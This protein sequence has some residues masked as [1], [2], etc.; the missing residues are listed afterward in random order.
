MSDYCD[1]LD[2]CEYVPCIV[3]HREPDKQILMMSN[4]DF[5]QLQKTTRDM[6]IF[7]AFSSLILK[8]RKMRKCLNF[9]GKNRDFLVEALAIPENLSFGEDG[10]LG[11]HITEWMLQQSQGFNEVSGKYEPSLRG[12]AAF[13]RSA[14]IVIEWI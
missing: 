13:I 5:F 1:E 10:C 6:L 2:C 3:H 12:F 14:P 8:L 11:M 7:Q 9:P 4:K